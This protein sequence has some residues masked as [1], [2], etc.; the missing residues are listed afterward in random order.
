MD[1]FTW[2]PYE[3]P[4][5]DPEFIVHK[6]NVD[7]SY[8]PKKQKP[9]RSAKDHVEAV[10]REVEKL[11]EAGVENVTVK[12]VTFR[13]IENGVRIKS[14]ERPS[15]G[16]SRNIVFQH[17]LMIDVQ[18][19][20]IIDQNYCP[21]NKDCPGQVRFKKYIYIYIYMYSGFRFKLG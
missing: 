6:L 13:G 12:S 15:N 5:V 10:R 2:K 16:F 11:K 8:P 20:I 18:N 4:E 14:W 9:R 17:V 21:N 3:V 1:V 19:P 7:P